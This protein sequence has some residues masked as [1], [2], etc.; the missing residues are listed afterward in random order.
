MSDDDNAWSRQWM[1]GP[2]EMSDAAQAYFGTGER[3]MEKILSFVQ[4][5]VPFRS[6]VDFGTAEGAWLVAARQL[7]ATEILGYDL[8]GT[9]LD[10]LKIPVRCFVERDLSLPI[11]PDRSF[12]IAISTEVAEHV[13]PDRVAV[14]IAN[15]AAASD[16][17]LFSA[18]LP[19]Q[20]G[21]GHQNE[22]WAEYWAKRFQDHG[23]A[24][25]DILRPHFWH[26]G[27]IRSYYRQNIFLYARG[28]PAIE[29]EN[30]GFKPT[31]RPLSL[32]HPEQYLKAIG[33]ALPPE[34]RRIGQDVTQYYDCVT[35][36]PDAID[37]DAD[38]QKYGRGEVGWKAILD[39]FGP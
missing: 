38:R 6:A 31:A 36:S 37:A 5:I 39:F 24:C 8:P 20:G 32:V 17:V 12:D 7:G 9:P 28:A 30:Q 33:R 22:L 15:V 27:S 3:G 11:T 34:L 26:D 2:N 14:F 16:L 23:F 29:L 1:P 18:A 10:R 35:R 4:D 19:Y 21:I 25:F 13:D